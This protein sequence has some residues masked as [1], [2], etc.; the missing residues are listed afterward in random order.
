MHKRLTR[1]LGSIFC[2][3]GL[4]LALFGFDGAWRAYG[5]TAGPTPTPDFDLPITKAVTPS[6]GLPGDTVTFSIN[7]TNDQPQTQTNVVVTD[8]V[9][10]FLEVVGASSSKGTASFSGQEVRADVGTLASGESVTLTITT[11]IQAG[12]AAGTVG[13]NVA[14]VN[15]ASGS[16]SSSNVVTVTVGGDTT[17]TP[18]PLPTQVPNGP[19]LVVEKSA[20]PASGKVG[21]L[22][23]FKIVVRN[24]GGAT[25]PDVVVN[26]RILD[27]LEVVGVQTSKGSATTTG[28]AVKVS[29]GDLAAGE[30]V[31]IVITTKIRAG[32]TSG[33][34]GINIAEAVASDGSGG[35]S[36]TPSN[37]VAI[38]VD[39]SAPVGLPDTSAPSQTAWIFWLGLGLAITGGLLLMVSR[40]RSEA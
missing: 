29:V 33:Q 7:V 20:S 12:T 16:S 39:R 24:T 2:V 5:Q 11:R 25:A 3:L 8:S 14:F 1:V 32:T 9:V 27:F 34:Q 13:Q 4:G 36:S 30:S 10:N 18:T 17:V 22:I 37:P 23:S 21:D 35:S 26:D 28:Q 38:A 15:T 6:N 19:K 40:R 31:T